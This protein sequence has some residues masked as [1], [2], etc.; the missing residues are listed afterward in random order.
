MLLQRLAWLRASW[1]IGTAAALLC[2]LA[3]CNTIENGLDATLSHDQ[4]DQLDVVRSADLRPVSAPAGTGSIGGSGS[5]S[6]GP[7][8]AATQASGPWLFPGDERQSATTDSHVRGAGGRLAAA[9]PGATVGAFGVE[10][11]FEN[12]DIQAVSKSIL[13]DVLGLNYLIDPRVQGTVTLASVGAIPR[14]DVL[15]VFESALRT[16]NAAVVRDGNILK[17]VP[18]SETNGSG[19]VSVGTGEPGFGVSVVPLRYTSAT[20]MA[21]MAENFLSRPGAMRADASGNLVMIQGT[22]AER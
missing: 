12:A 21:K 3:G 8:N 14:K 20:A 17:I 1:G 22:M 16:A 10:L 6:D 19:T 9:D 5:P 11:N 18:L 13:S 4:H 7:R 2:L 15:T